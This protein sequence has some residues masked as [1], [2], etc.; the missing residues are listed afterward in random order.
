MAFD[1]TLP[2]NSTKI[3]RYPE[4]LTDNF[5]AIQTGDDT[6]QVWQLNFIDRDLVPGAPPP[7]QDPTRVDDTIIIYS[8]QNADGE[9]DLFLMDDRAIANIIQV[10]QD[11]AL[12]STSTSLNAKDLSFDVDPTT[13]LTYDDGQFITAYGKFN[14]AG[15]LLFGKNMA[16]SGTPHPSTGLFNITVSANVLQNANYIITG[17]VSQSGDSNASIRGLMPLLTPAPVAG[18]PTI[19]QVEIKRDGGRANTF[20][21]FMVMICGGR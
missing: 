18:N 11:G 1:K 12:G 20:D 3:R 21:Y 6:F 14:S 7:T 2:Q 9:T 16:T 13:G 4:V 10:S 19:I 5:A 15:V 17:N 8:K